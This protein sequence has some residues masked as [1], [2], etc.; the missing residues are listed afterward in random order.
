MFSQLTYSPLYLV[1]HFL[2]FFV[3][4]FVP[5]C[6]LSTTFARLLLSFVYPSLLAFTKKFLF[7]VDLRFV[8][9]LYPHFVLVQVSFFL[10]KLKSG[11]SISVLVSCFV[12]I[13]MKCTAAF[14]LIATL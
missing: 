14:F 1:L 2:T 6:A 8:S 3:Y 12:F 11:V 4:Q 13:A 5:H 9:V 10:L 7:F